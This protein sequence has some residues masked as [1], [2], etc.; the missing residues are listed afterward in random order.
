MTPIYI[1]AGVRTAIGDFGGSLKDCPPATLGAA[2]IA[3]AI[4]RAGVA[5]DQIGHVVKWRIAQTVEIFFL[6]YP[7]V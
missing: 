6:P 2:V 7:N 4:A 5:A 3:E 1:L